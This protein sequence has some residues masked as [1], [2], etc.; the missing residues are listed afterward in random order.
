MATTLPQ[1][2]SGGARLKERDDDRRGA[3]P[4]RMGN[5]PFVVTDE[6]RAK[7]RTLAK[8]MK[9][10]QQ[11]ARSWI[12][13]QMGIS[14][15]TLDR[16]FSEELIAG[17]AEIVASVGATFVGVVMGTVTVSKERLDAMKFFLS[18]MGGWS[19]KLEVGGIPGR[20]IETVDLTGLSAAAFREYGRQ[21]AIQAGLD[22]DEAVGPPLDDD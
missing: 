16:H 9:G 17:R 21:A 15:S 11:A 6:M 20:P 1:P 2:L 5:P 7:C 3:P 8:T 22:P 19:T 13:S 10:E 18:R 14:V 12:A 4:G